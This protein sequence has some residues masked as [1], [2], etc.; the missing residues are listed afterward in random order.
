MK[1][2]LILCYLICI[3]ATANAGYGADSE[4]QEIRIGVLLPITGDWSSQGAISNVALGIADDD[5]NRFLKDI[6]SSWRVN[7]TTV[8]TGTDPK[9]ALRELKNL[10]G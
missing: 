7:L 1:S 2:Y 4:A 5:V 3:M 8:D 10:G 9:T 6:G